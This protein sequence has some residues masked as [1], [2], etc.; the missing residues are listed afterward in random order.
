MYWDK[1]ETISKPWLFKF[2]IQR[3]G[4]VLDHC[5]AWRVL[6]GR[7][8]NSLWSEVVHEKERW[9]ALRQAEGD[10]RGDRV[11]WGASEKS[12]KDLQQRWRG[13]VTGLNEW[14][15]SLH[16]RNHQAR[17][18]SSKR[19]WNHGREDTIPNWG[20]VS[21]EDDDCDWGKVLWARWGGTKWSK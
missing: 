16:G 3:L 19:A 7:Q 6:V 17:I 5:W 18:G 2:S 11:I 21:S 4:E 9:E 10:K 14:C 15:W 12:R 8:M 20:L 13:E 1:R